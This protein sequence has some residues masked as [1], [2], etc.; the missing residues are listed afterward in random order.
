MQLRG[1]F[2]LPT[3]CQDALW[4]YRGD[5]KKGANIN[6]CYDLLT[7]FGMEKVVIAFSDMGPKGLEIALTVPHADYWLDPEPSTWDNCFKSKQASR[8]G[9]DIQGV[10][11]AY[12]LKESAIREFLL[13]LLKTLFYKWNGNVACTDKNMVM[14]TTC[15]YRFFRSNRKCLA[16]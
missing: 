14:H 8:S 6:A 2:K 9:Y 7:R 10:A 15:I 16:M 5:H 4:I 13:S 3:L 1:A 11:M 12:L